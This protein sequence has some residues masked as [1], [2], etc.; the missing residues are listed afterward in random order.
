MDRTPGA[1]RF[2]PLPQFLAVVPEEM[3]CPNR[4]VLISEQLP[5]YRILNQV[6]FGV[7][8]VLVSFL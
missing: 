1:V 6:V 2:R 5:L 7:A 8:I 4:Q 3:M